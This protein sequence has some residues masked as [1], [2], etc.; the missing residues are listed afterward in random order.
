MRTKTP[1]LVVQFRPQLSG[2]PSDLVPPPRSK[3]TWRAWVWQKMAAAAI[4]LS[5][6]DL[7]DLA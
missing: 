1:H 4:T 2:Y 7:A 6:R 3:P 5:E